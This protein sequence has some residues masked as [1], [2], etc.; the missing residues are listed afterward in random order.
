MK[1]VKGTVN[2]FAKFVMIAGF[3]AGDVVEKYID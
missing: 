1:L 3:V 2:Y